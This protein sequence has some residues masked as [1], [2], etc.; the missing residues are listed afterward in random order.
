MRSFI[1]AVAAAIVLA[2]GFYAVLNA[3]QMSADTKFQ[4][5]GVR[6]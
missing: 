6:L 1:I 2:L 5:E 3:V 4:T